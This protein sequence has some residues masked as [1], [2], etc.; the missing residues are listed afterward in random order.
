VR[1]HH[2]LHYEQYMQ[3]TSN[4]ILGLVYAAIVTVESNEHY[5][6]WVCL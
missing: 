6:W 3:C 4:V 2:G 5:I 1:L